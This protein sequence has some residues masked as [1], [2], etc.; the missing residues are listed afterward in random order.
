MQ[1]AQI[2]AT[3]KELDVDLIVLARYMQVPYCAP[4]NLEGVACVSN[5]YL[6]GKHMGV[7]S[8]P[9]FSAHTMLC[10]LNV[11]TRSN[12]P[13]KQGGHSVIKQL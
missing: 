4:T 6:Q 12:H 11:T 5:S 1:E 10:V 8:P 13:Q 9:S 7:C 2:E 3:L